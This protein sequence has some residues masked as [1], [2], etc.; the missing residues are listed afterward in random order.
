MRRSANSRPSASSRDRKDST[1]LSES[2]KK[3]AGPPSPA[4]PDRNLAARW[5]LSSAPL[6]GRSS[7]RQSP[8]RDHASIP[9]ARGAVRQAALPAAVS[10]PATDGGSPDPHSPRRLRQ[11]V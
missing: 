6:G 1:R 3:S 2:I 7:R 11:R 8:V 4:A 5:R 10:A 9:P